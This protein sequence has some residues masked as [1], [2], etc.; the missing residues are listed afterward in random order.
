MSQKGK[1]PKSGAG[2]EL[3][4]SVKVRGGKMDEEKDVFPSK[5]DTKMVATSIRISAKLL[6]EIDALSKERD[7]SRNEVIQYCLEFAIEAH[8][9]KER[10]RKQAQK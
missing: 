9:E 7:L 5:D 1:A 4:L 2:A 3:G 8:R 10:K 6:R